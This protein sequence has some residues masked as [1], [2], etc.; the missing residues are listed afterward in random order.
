MV[1]FLE[2]RGAEPN[3]GRHLFGELRGAGLE[4][5]EAA[6]RV[7]VMRGDHPSSVLPRYTMERVGVPAVAAGLAAE[8]DFGEALA[9]LA[10]PAV[11]VMSHVM[12]AAWGRRPES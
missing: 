12:M 2:S 10:D 6:G 7:Y 8:A 11:A 4:G 5:V 3:H 1:R 9:L